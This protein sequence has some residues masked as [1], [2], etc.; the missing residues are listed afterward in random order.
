MSHPKNVFSSLKN[1]LRKHR[2]VHQSNNNN[3]NDNDND[4]NNDTVEPR[5]SG[6]VGTSVNSPDNRESG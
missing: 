4:K 5:L 3:N 6:L 2:V 1:E